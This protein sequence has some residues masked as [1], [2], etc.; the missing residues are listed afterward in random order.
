MNNNTCLALWPIHRPP[1]VA[2]PVCVFLRLD[3]ALAV[4]GPPRPVGAVLRWAGPPGPPPQMAQQHGSCRRVPLQCR[5]TTTRAR[6]T[7]LNLPQQCPS[8]V[9]TRRSDAPLFVPQEPQQEG[10]CCAARRGACLGR[11]SSKRMRRRRSGLCSA[12][13]GGS[14][15]SPDPATATV[16]AGV[17][18]GASALELQV[19][20]GGAATGIGTAR[21]EDGYANFQ[22]KSS[23]RPTGGHGPSELPKLA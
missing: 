15:L 10:A 22:G 18:A 12:G 19:P 5:G 2:I 4:E 13:G 23:A 1:T 3:D 9:D 17:T 8:S 20:R 6:H 21:S 7:R 11:A 16:C 14:M